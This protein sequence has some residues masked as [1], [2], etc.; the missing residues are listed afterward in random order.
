MTG[1]T[2]K[3]K[4]VKEKRFLR[5]QIDLIYIHPDFL[6]KIMKIST[7]VKSKFQISNM[8]YLFQIKGDLHFFKKKSKPAKSEKNQDLPSNSLIVIQGARREKRRY[9]WESHQM[10][11][12]T[13]MKNRWI[14][15]PEQV[16]NLIMKLTSQDQTRWNTILQTNILIQIPL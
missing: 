5:K 16:I 13:K 14:W 11:K 1:I 2:W 15:I 8:F 6:D 12:M 9:L 4:K 10:K 3:G 7:L